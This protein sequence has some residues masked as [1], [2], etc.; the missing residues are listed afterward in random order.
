MTDSRPTWDDWGLNLARAVAV[1]GDCSRR[2]VGSVILDTDH[3]VVSTGYN[4]APSGQP[5]C[6]DGFCP[7]ALASP[8]EIQSNITDYEN[9][10]GRCI[11]VHAE[12]NALLWADPARTKGGTMYNTH[13]PCNW[14]F[15][16]IGG[17]GLLTLM[18]PTANSVKRVRFG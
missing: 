15:K 8:E 17:S 5:G 9:G 10:P 18:W 2:Q 4:G 16:V 1:R 14:C 7:R 3:R 11:A 6:L 12:T 13:A